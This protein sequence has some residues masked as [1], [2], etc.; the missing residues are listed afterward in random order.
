MST[1]KVCVVSGGS[2]GIGL[3]VVEAFIDDGYRVFNLDLTPGVVGEYI[4]CD[5]TQTDQVEQAVAM[6][7]AAVSRI[8]ALVSNAGI[9]I[10]GSIE[11]TDEVD[12]DRVMDV[13]VKGAY[14]LVK[15]ALPVMK[16]TLHGAIVLIASDQAL[17][18]KPNSFVYN[19]SKTALVSMARTT[20]L[21][22]A[23]YGIRCNAVCPGTVDTPL[24]HQAIVNYCNKSGEEPS[25]VH[26]Q[27]AS[28]QPLGRI[29]Q[30]KEVADLVHFLCSDKAAF[31][32]GSLQLIDGGYTAR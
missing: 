30:P 32:T 14:R 12:F 24:Y 19:M 21:D 6:I 28:L 29:G 2:A 8:D 5:M 22:Y 4:Q 18:G 17:I 11:D 26:R 9:H 25:S 16:P 3:A 15:A 27:E 7:V 20:A 10:S 23:M 31:I 13:N 1:E